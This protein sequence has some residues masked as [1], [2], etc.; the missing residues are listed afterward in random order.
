[1]WILKPGSGSKGKGI[2]IHHTYESIIEEIK[3]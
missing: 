2:T 1:M 3:Q